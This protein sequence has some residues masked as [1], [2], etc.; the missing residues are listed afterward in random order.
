MSDVDIR[1]VASVGWIGRSVDRKAVLE[2]QAFPPA[3][4]PQPLIRDGTL[5]TL[6]APSPQHEMLRLNVLD[7]PV[8]LHF[9]EILLAVPS[10]CD[11]LSSRTW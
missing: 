7:D 11:M 10:R 9:V 1:L 8:F 6:S 4:T 5:M 3:G 2:Y